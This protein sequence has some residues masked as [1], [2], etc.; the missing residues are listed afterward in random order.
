MLNNSSVCKDDKGFIWTASRSGVMRLT[1]DSYRMYSLP[2]EKHNAIVVKLIHQNFEL[3]AYANNGQI[4]RYN[5]MLDRFDNLITIDKFNIGIARIVG[6]NKGVYWLATNAGLYKYSKGTSISQIY[7]YDFRD[8]VW[9]NDGQ[10]IVAT[11]KKIGLFDVRTLKI[12]TIYEYPSNQSFDV[13]KLFFD[14]ARRKLWIGTMSD[15]LCYYDFNNSTFTKSTINGLPKQPILAIDANSDS[16]VLIGID[17]HGI[18]KLDSR[19]DKLLGVSLENVDDPFSLP[20]NGVYDIYCDKQSGRVWVCSVSGGVSYFEQV[21]L[22]IILKKHQ[23]NNDNSL[24]NNCVNKIFKD[25]K[26]NLWFATNNGVSYWDVHADKWQTYYKNKSEQAQV[27]LSVCEDN[28][29]QIWCGTYSSG[30]YVV[31]RQTGK[32]VAHYTASNTKAITDFVF[33]IYKD[34]QGDIWIGGNRGN[35]TCYLSKEKKF[36]AY[37]L[38]N[39]YSIVELSPGKMLFGCADGLSILDKLTGKIETFGTSSPCQDII[40]Y[41]GTVWICSNGGGLMKFDLKKKKYKKIQIQSGLPSDFVTS[42]MEAGGAL[43]VGTE[44]G[45]CKINPETMKTSHIPARFIPS[46]VSFNRDAHCMLTNGYL[47]WGTNQGIIII[48]PDLLKAKPL[49][50]KIFIQDILVSGSSIRNN[51]SFKLTTTLDSL[52][53]ITLPYNQNNLTME[54][55]TLGHVQLKSKF[56]WIL[57]GVDATPS[58]PTDYRTLNYSNIPV[59]KFVLKIKMYDNSLSQLVAERK[60][61]IRVTPPFWATWWFRFLM[62]AFVAGLFYFIMRFYV[63][64]LK[65]FHTEDKMRFF[66]NIAHEIRTTITLIKSPLEELNKIKF[67]VKEQYYVNL[68]TEQARQLSTTVTQL[69][70]FQ[71]TDI[72][73]DQLSLKMIDIVALIQYRCQM[74]EVLAKNKN[75]KLAFTANPEI[76][77]TAVDVS[78]MEQV[79]DNLLSNAIKYSYSDKQVQILF[80]GNATNWILEV[81][82]Y[83]IGINSKVQSKLFREFYRGDNAM[84]F[85]SVGSGIGLLLAKS[86]V[87]LHNGTIHCVSEE[88]EGSSFKITIPFKESSLADDKPQSE[89]APIPVLNHIE[90]PK[91]NSKKKLRLLIVEDNDDLQNFMFNALCDEFNVSV[92]NDGEIAWKIIKKQMPDIVVSDVMMPNMDG[93]E[94]CRL[95]KSTYETSHIPVLLLTSLAGRAEQLQGLGLGA[96]S[97]LTKPFDM[98]L[99]TQSVRSIIQNRKIVRDKALKI[100]EKDSNEVLFSNEL[101]DK[102][103]KKATE[104]VWAS[105][106]NPEFDKE[107]FAS[108]MNVSTSLLYKKI[109]SLTDKS[110]NEFT[111]SIKLNH[112]LKLLQEHSHS[113]TE[114]SE[115]CGFSSLDYFGK[116]FKSYFGKSPS[117]INVD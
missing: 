117:D 79:M 67:P 69:L 81:K 18:L 90:M 101:N 114:V 38:W 65:Q 6:D 44:N 57:E 33:D 24:Y 30:V 115:L 36:R 50:G 59:G 48:N 23:I 15:G 73:K 53:E 61:I 19:Y 103:I 28:E 8:I 107:E 102:F 74:F 78:K 87:S 55:L 17:G 113:I 7:D 77:R 2:F 88:N 41:K 16:T 104:V 3:L 10:L 11:D 34:I 35:V 32:E 56:S 71:K 86:Y 109:K 54:L 12:K 52:N 27:F 111:N 72:G 29:G 5:T 64:R 51:S 97:Y 94:L 105:M 76:Y 96:D 22:P 83:G 106:S 60:F 45:L 85:N 70:D 93:F 58:S 89:I 42:I 21:P 46:G 43:W 98:G 63:N 92:A 99:V 25:S 62:F 110:P 80:E 49:D 4:F 39:I 66:T 9:Y 26:G 108:A 91:D 14:K 75:I 100:I 112:A 40:L 31:N 82:D 47:L 13:T 116:A 95:I 84:N 68:A 37:S 20:G 1:D